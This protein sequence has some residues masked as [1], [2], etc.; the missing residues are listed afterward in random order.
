VR[1][2]S[3]RWCSNPRDLRH[4]FVTS[5]WRVKIDEFHIMA[6]TEHKMLRVLQRYNLIGEGDL[7]EAMAIL[8]TYLTPHEHEM[9][10]YM[11]TIPS[12]PL[13]PRRKDVVNPRR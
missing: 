10:T 5:A 6:I 9:D 7:Q 12:E 2:Q 11:D 4:T 13:A 1:I 3:R 8:H